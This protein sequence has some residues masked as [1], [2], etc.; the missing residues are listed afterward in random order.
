VLFTSGY[1]A[2]AVVRQFGLTENSFAF[3]AKPYGL[4][5]LTREV[6]RVLDE[7]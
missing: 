3:I 7:G 6:R 5:D 2:D 4:A 1:S